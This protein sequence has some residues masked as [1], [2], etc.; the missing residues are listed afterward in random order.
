MMMHSDEVRV[1]PEAASRLIVEQFPQWSHLPIRAVV[2][3]GTDHA[4]YRIGDRL[5]ARFPL[6]AL[7][8]SETR[9]RL[10]AEASAARELAVCSSVSTSDRSRSASL[11]RVTRLRGRFRLGYMVTSLRTTI[12]VAQWPLLAISLALSALSVRREAYS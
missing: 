10:V 11:D 4:I 12:R 2:A 9:C 3:D 7:N 8:P 6:R 5:A 1:T